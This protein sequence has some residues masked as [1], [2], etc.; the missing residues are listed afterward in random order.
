MGA[1]EEPEQRDWYVDSNGNRKEY[2]SKMASSGGY[3][4]A[5]GDAGAG[6]PKKRELKKGFLSD[7][8]GS[9]YGPEGS[10]QGSIPKPMEELLQSEAGKGDQSDFMRE[11]SK[12]MGN[13]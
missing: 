2:P 6:P 11:F 12:M 4:V 10:A 8:K 13:E 1:D 7:A 3:A 5:P 9:L